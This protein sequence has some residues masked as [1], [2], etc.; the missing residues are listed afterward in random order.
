[1][2]VSRR[3]LAAWLD[4]RLR[5]AEIPDHACNGLQV[6]GTARISRVALAVDAC[7]AAY[8]LAA[9]RRCQLLLVHHGLIWDG[10]TSVRGYYRRHL[11]CLFRHDLNLYAA[12]LPLDMHPEIGN[13]IQIARALNLENIRPFGDYHRQ[14]I[15]Y[16][17]DLPAALPL[18]KLAAGLDAA[19][20]GRALNLPA[21]RKTVRS[22]GIVS[23]GGGT[24]LFEAAGENLDCFVTGERSHAQYHPAEETGT[25]VIYLG[26]Y[27]SE[28]FG[29]QA[30]GREL[31]AQ[32]GLETVFLDLPPARP[33]Q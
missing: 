4:R 22:V 13:N 16:A 3:R 9:A 11:H 33:F 5:I 1:M 6:E 15:G 8:R 12:H 10:I 19:S 25:S 18:D 2:A 24:I 31:A 17:G 26:H 20:G 23:G 28:T 27:H 32:F 7:L 14:T 21:G 30:L 29:V